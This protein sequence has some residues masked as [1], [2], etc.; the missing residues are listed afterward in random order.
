MTAVKQSPQPVSNGPL[1][2]AQRAALDLIKRGIMPIPVP[3]GTKNPSDRRKWQDERYTADDLSAFAHEKL[4]VGMRLGHITDSSG[5]VLTDKFV[6]IDLDCAEA[7]RAARFVL[8]PTGMI[9]GRISN[10]RSHYGYR[11]T[12][13]DDTQQHDDHRCV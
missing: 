9:W 11:L 7:V 12:S 8:P 2:T 10:P 13:T 5:R 6:D 1:T 4:N 3:Y